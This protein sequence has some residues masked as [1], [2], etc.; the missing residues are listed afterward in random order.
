[1]TQVAALSPDGLVTVLSRLNAARRADD[2]RI[3]SAS[4]KS[5][6]EDV[7]ECLFAASTR[8]AAY[9]SLAPGEL[10]HDVVAGLEGEWSEGFVHGRLDA[11]GWGAWLGFPGMVW[12]P[13]AP[14]VEVRVLTSQDLPDH[15]S[16]LDDFEGPAYRRILVPVYGPVGLACV[17]G[18]YELRER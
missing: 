17:A 18:I 1:M 4:D 14:G 13:D 2:G 16:R 11:A 6:L 15:W 10:N 5:V 3:G 8:F 9:G 7:V 12:D